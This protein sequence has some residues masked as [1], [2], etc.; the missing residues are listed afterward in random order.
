MFLQVKP[1]A[2]VAARSPA[3]GIRQA[4]LIACICLLLAMAQL[5]IAG[6]SFGVGSQTLQVPLL[7]QTI[8]RGLYSRDAMIATT[9]GDYP[10]VFFRMLAMPARIAPVPRL[11]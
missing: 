5:L 3:I 7:Q 9:A 10:T 1:S 11:F 2:I 6:S 8:D 4:V